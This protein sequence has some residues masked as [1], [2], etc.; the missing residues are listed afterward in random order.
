MTFIRGYCGDSSWI[1]GGAGQHHE[2]GLP[3][4]LPAVGQ[5]LNPV[6][7]YK[8]LGGLL[9]WG[10]VTNVNPKLLYWL[11]PEIVGPHSIRTVCG[12]TRF[13]NYTAID[14]KWFRDQ[15]CHSVLIITAVVSYACNTPHLPLPW[16]EHAPSASFW[17]QLRTLRIL[18]INKTRKD[19]IT[20]NGPSPFTD[21]H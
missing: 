19:E 1:S 21:Y 5:A 2:T 6:H 8:L 10:L 4:M 15:P 11:S 17:A 7:S 18:G 12:K 20:Y 9:H 14:S 13:L 16:N 3:K